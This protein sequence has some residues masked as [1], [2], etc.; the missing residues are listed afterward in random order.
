M[1]FHRFDAQSQANKTRCLQGWHR[2]NT[3]YEGLV[4]FRLSWLC[5]RLQEVL[6]LTQTDTFMYISM[7]LC[8]YTGVVVHVE[9]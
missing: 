8:G 1:I 4:Y 7:T 9:L 6:R 5:H 3:Y 2:N